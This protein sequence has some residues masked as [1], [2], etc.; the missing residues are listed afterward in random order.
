MAELI[1]TITDDPLSEI[2]DRWTRAERRLEEMM[3]AAITMARRHPRRAA[4]L[5]VRAAALADVLGDA[6][7]SA[8][9][10][11]LA[12]AWRR[13]SLLR[14]IGGVGLVTLA[15]AIALMARDVADTDSTITTTPPD[16]TQPVPVTTT[17]VEWTAADGD[18][19]PSTF[20]F[21]D[22]SGVMIA[23]DGAA[24]VVR[25]GGTWTVGLRIT[26]REVGV[27]DTDGDLGRAAERCR[28]GT[29]IE[30]TDG[31][32]TPGM[33]SVRLTRTDG[34]G[35]TGGSI[36]AGQVPFNPQT[37]SIAAVPDTCGELTMMDGRVLAEHSVIRAGQSA[38]FDLDAA[39]VPG[40]WD[41]TIDMGGHPIESMI[42]RV[43]LVVLPDD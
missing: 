19:G 14:W 39:T 38:T 42:G 34:D 15:A 8:M 18:P 9:A 26:S 24:P 17:A 13:R 43:R 10:M 31:A 1:V 23:V 20:T 33:F 4:A 2:G 25:P 16:S 30:I 3:R 29:P 28:L 21:A 40:L 32:L 37:D 36:V 41:V 11:D 27:F 35:G 12:K 7:R 22:G 6:T 5:A